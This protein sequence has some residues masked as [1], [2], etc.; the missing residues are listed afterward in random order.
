M[1]QQ[2][3]NPY[4]HK[5]FLYTSDCTTCGSIFPDGETVLRGLIDKAGKSLVV[6]QITLYHG[7]KAESD[8]IANRLNMTVPFFW[9]YDTDKVLSWKEAYDVAYDE[10]ETPTFTFNKRNVES[11]LGGN[12]GQE[13]QESESNNSKEN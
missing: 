4:E 13:T 12:N 1:E 2:K 8:S 11:F 7:W 10:K 5:V 3:R 9:D 6:K